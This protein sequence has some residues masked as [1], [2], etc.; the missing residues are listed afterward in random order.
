MIIRSRT[1]AALP[2][3]S[4]IGLGKEAP[5]HL[6]EKESHSHLSRGHVDPPKCFTRFPPHHSSLLVTSSVSLGKLLPI[7][8]PLSPHL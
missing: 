2:G 3:A 4:F 1:V 7:P 5:G 6:G 8:G